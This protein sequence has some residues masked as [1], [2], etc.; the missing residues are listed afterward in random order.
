MKTSEMRNANGCVSRRNLGADE[1]TLTSRMKEK[2]TIKILYDATKI[3]SK[4]ESYL[5]PVQYEQRFHYFE[6]FGTYEAHYGF[7]LA[8]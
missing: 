7:G 3:P 6:T 2:G 1:S 8:I 4:N 5:L